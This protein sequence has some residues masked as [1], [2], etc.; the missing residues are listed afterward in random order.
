M[1]VLVISAHPDDETLGCGA[2]LL[3]H[4][5]AKHELHWLI[6][7]ETWQPRWDV[8]VTETKQ[9]EVEVVAQAYG[10]AGVHRLRLP[11][12]KLDT[13]PLGQLVESINTVAEQTR[14]EIVY[15]PH[16]GDTHS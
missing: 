2:S 12:M 7:T 9:R 3:R 13:V 6:A 10:M 8:A 16:H 4:R 5:S 1:T 15:V 14:P 11:S